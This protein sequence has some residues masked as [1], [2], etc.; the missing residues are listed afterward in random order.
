[1]SDRIAPRLHLIDV[2]D[3]R[4]G[5]T[6]RDYLTRSAIPFTS[7]TATPPFAGEVHGVDLTNRRLPVLL[8]D[9]AVVLEDPSPAEVA[10]HLGWV[11]PPRRRRYD[12]LIF[13]AGP[14]GLSAAVYAASEGL[15]V[16]VIERDAVGGQ[17]GSSSLIEN[18]LGF[19]NG[20]S[21]A[22]LADHARQ[23]AVRFGAEFVLMREGVDR[24][25]RDHD[26]RAVLADGSRLDADAAVCATGIQWR[27]L[28][29]AREAEYFRAGVYYGAG[30]SEAPA[31]ADQ[32]VYVVGGANSAGQAAMNLAAYARCVTLIVR[33]PSLSSTM[34]S[35]LS[36]RVLTH[37]RI[38]VLTD[39][40]VVG[41]DGDTRLRQIT[42]DEHGALRTL[43]ARHLFVCIGGDPNTRWAA[44]T[45]VELDARGFVATGP[46]L[47]PEQRAAWPL[48]RDPFFLETS[49]PGIFAAGD[50]R[51]NSIKRVASA[52]GEG[53]MAV[54]LVHR[55]LSAG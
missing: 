30:T 29:L 50:V 12:V 52:V 31:C 7:D 26:V 9:G 33:G 18:Y 38:R 54:T 51:S 16:A 53:A 34:S 43:P 17:A 3:S 19:P 55:Y 2:A 36:T 11:L 8:I 4:D 40:R 23:Q 5:F 24:T 35:Y 21:G 20:I 39:A 47:T 49:V 46:D 48:A 37:P 22:E 42:L 6:L 32:D 13:G 44:Q 45:D 27:R 28:G 41:L 15:D 10:M 25:F 1:M 14:A